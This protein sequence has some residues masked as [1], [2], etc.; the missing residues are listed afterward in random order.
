MTAIE[1]AKD[2]LILARDYIND[3]SLL[4]QDM[5]HPYFKTSDAIDEAIAEIEKPNGIAK[6][7]AMCK[8][9]KVF[10]ESYH[11]Q[12]CAEC[13]HKQFTRFEPI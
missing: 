13:Y 12:K 9:M 6:F 11:Q 3:G 4:P 5:N 1:M 10:A 8:Q 7:N 2:A